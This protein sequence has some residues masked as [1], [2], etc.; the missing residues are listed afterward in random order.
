MHGCLITEWE[1]THAHVSLFP[2]PFLDL[3]PQVAV[4][5][6]GHLSRPSFG[7]WESSTKPLASAPRYMI[8]IFIPTALYLLHGRCRASRSCAG[9]S[10]ENRPAGPARGAHAALSPRPPP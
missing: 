5:F 6:N 1:G 7:Q 10:G 9:A 2:P 4:Q 8:G 3:L